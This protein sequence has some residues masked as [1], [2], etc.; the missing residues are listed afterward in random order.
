VE[1]KENVYFFATRLHKDQQT[2][3]ENFA[4]C[5]K[6]ITAQVLRQLG[7]LPAL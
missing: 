2:K 7:I 1:T 4:A 5:R 6:S 3:N